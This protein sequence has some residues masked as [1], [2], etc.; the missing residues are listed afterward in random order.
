MKRN[1]VDIKVEVVP[2]TELAHTLRN[3]GLMVAGL[4][5][6]ATKQGAEP[7][8]ENGVDPSRESPV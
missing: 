2:D 4:N 3:E 8:A 1:G 6:K 7:A 5:I